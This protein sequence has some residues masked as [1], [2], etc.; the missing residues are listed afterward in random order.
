MTTPRDHVPRTR[1]RALFTFVIVSAPLAFVACSA[2]SALHP[3]D[4]STAVPCK[5]AAAFAMAE[6]PERATNAKCESYSVM[7]RSYRG[8]WQMPRAD[9]DAWIT[10]YFPDRE[11]SPAT[12]T[13]CGADLCVRVQRDPMAQTTKGAYDIGVDIH[14]E[15][16]GTALVDYSST[17]Y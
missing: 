9:V 1:T 2:I 10:R 6:L 7:D 8:T 12:Y 5:E 17:D 16:D 3:G 11:P 14:F 13:P 4:L 15:P